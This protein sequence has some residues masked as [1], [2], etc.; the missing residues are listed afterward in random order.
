MKTVLVTGGA[1]YIGSHVSMKLSKEGVIP[2]C[3]D[4][5]STGNEWAIKWGPFVK[6][7]IS[8]I[9]LLRRTFRK[10]DISAVLHFAGSAYVGE[11]VSAPEKYYENN[12]A[13]GL[14]LLTAMRLEGVNNLIFSSS[15]A[16][17]GNPKSVLIDETTPQL[18]INPY[19]RTKLIFENILK[20]YFSSYSLNSMSLRYFNAAGAD[21]SAEIGECHSPC[22]HLIPNLIKSFYRKGSPLVIN[23]D[24]FETYDGTCIRDFIH[25]QDLAEAHFKAL[26]DILD[27]PQCSQLN[28]GTGR[29]Y[30]IMELL[31]ITSDLLGMPAN[32]LIGDRREGDPSALVADPALAYE[33]LGWSPKN[34][35]EDILR[36]AINWHAK[37]MD[38]V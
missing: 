11:S 20:D 4:D 19:G 13:G 10:Y 25:V 9:D 30:S 24:D 12:V 32:Y 2:V 15:C 27:R 8:D 16:T 28:L 18:P 31:K 7:T 14:S 23:G 17:Y 34:S 21:S 29:G 33:K 1:G 36:D 35:I 26:M 22:P 6:G 5:L 37:E 3:F 38:C